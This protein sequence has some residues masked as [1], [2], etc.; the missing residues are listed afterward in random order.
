MNQ[1]TM[2]NNKNKRKPFRAIYNLY[3]SKFLHK[4]VDLEKRLEKITDLSRNVLLGL[5]AVY[6]SVARYNRYL[7]DPKCHCFG[8][9]MD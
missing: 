5:L 1:R 9:L 3:G 7:V 6:W 8:F 2:N 4:I